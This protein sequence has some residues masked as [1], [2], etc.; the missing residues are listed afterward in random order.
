MS[1]KPILLYIFIFLFIPVYLLQN[2]PDNFFIE[3]NPY[4]NDIDSPT[5]DYHHI[6]TMVA[7]NKYIDHYKGIYYKPD[8]AC[9]WSPNFNGQLSPVRNSI[10]IPN[11]YSLNNINETNLKELHHYGC[12]NQ[13]LAVLVDYNRHAEDSLVVVRMR[14]TNPGEEDITLSI[15]KN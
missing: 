3:D 4:N 6:I 7:A 5:E 1:S 11:Y 10:E 9:Y 8:L 15:L 14:I 13:P 2:P 12:T